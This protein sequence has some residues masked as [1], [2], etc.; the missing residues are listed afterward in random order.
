MP[1]ESGRNACFKLIKSLN[2]KKAAQA[3][4]PDLQGLYD[5]WKPIL[6]PDDVPPPTPDQASDIQS[7]LDAA[8]L[9][10]SSQ[11][12]G[13]SILSFLPSNPTPQPYPPFTTQPS[14]NP[15]TPKCPCTHL[16]RSSSLCY[17]PSCHSLCDYSELFRKGIFSSY[18]HRSPPRKAS[19]PDGLPPV[20]FANAMKCDLF[21]SLW[22]TRVNLLFFG[23]AEPD[24]NSWETNSITVFI[25]KSDPSSMRPLALSSVAHKQAEAILLAR[26]HALDRRAP[27]FSPFQFGFRKGFDWRPPS[28]APRF[29]CIPSQ[30]L[31]NAAVR[32]LS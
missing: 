30:L 3:A 4:P 28:I 22:L 13:E 31:P 18:L 9:A 10:D 15:P 6:S 16:T 1:H 7:L 20:A 17:L 14:P 23:R 19:G 8:T 21:S 26:L 32:L 25:P 11:P 24:A 12:H 27:L 5:K 2:G 29:P